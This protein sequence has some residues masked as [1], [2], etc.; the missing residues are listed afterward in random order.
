MQNETLVAKIGEIQAKLEIEFK[1]LDG[2]RNLSTQLT[3][4]DLLGQVQ[5]T[6]LDSQRRIQYLESEKARLAEAAGGPAAVPYVQETP[7]STRRASASA[8]APIPN[9]P[10]APPDPSRTKSHGPPSAFPQGFMSL[11]RN[12]RDGSAQQSEEYL[13]PQ[14]Q[15]PP[16]PPKTPP[17][18]GGD[19]PSARQAGMLYNVLARLGVRTPHS[20]A[21]HA[22]YVWQSQAL[23]SHKEFGSTPNL[24]GAQGTNPS[25]SRDAASDPN[26]IRPQEMFKA[27]VPF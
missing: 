18:P 22:A 5:Q 25:L 9:A 12:P 7:S 17:P 26:L 6:I 4:P 23:G 11:D 21:A 13:A 8:F 10:Y 27:L 24:G 3:N 16:L 19:P 1:C 15:Y 2:A 20:S 14:E